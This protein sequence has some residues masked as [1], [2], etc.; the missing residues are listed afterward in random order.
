MSRRLVNDQ[1]GLYF[2][3]VLD[4]TRQNLLATQQMVEAIALQDLLSSVIQTDMNGDHF[5]GD[6]EL[7]MLAFRLQQI[8][9]VP[10]SGEEL[11]TRFARW[12]GTKNLRSLVDCVRTLYIEK[13]REQVAAKEAH[14]TERLPRQLGT[15]LLW[16]DKMSYGVKIAH[17]VNA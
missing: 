10:F 16:N 7:N 2:L 3:A 6:S 9:G 17:G 1:F 8:E 13:R 5:I 14:Q 11:C 4:L 15:H 12:P